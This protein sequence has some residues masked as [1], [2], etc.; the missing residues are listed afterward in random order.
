MRVFE[1]KRTISTM[2]VATVVV[3]IV[4]CKRTTAGTAG[5]GG[6]PTGSATPTTRAAG[7]SGAGAMAV[8]SDSA[9][10][11]DSAA[12]SVMLNPNGVAPTTSAPCTTSMFLPTLGTT[13]QVPTPFSTPPNSASGSG[14]LSSGSSS[15]TSGSSATAPISPFIPMLP[16]MNPNF[17]DSNAVSRPPAS[18][19]T[20]P[21]N[22]AR[23]NSTMVH[24]TT[25]GSTA[26]FPRRPE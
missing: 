13:V 8:S 18:A 1:C 20:N 2:L 3:G 10:R 15:S 7:S 5:E 19:S 9:G 25:P 17:V 16:T 11:V 21:L 23:P 26:T 24:P 6:N 22:T 14:A 12:G 4:G